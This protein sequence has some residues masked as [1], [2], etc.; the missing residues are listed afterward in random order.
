[1]IFI[2]A[3]GALASI[4]GLVWFGLFLYERIKKKNQPATSEELK[5][6]ILRLRDD[7]NKQGQKM[8]MLLDGLPNAPRPIQELL[9]DALLAEKENRPKDAINLWKQIELRPEI[10]DTGLCA[11][12]LQLADLNE[13]IAVYDDALF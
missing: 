12:Y 5:Q 10:G 4:A 11:V 6:E 8:D 2:V 9:R 1:M 3:L 13:G 7:L